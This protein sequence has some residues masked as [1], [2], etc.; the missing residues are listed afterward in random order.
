MGADAETGERLWRA[1]NDLANLAP[2]VVDGT[3]FVVADHSIKAF[4]GAD[5]EKRW[6]FELED[7]P[8]SAATVVDNTA[9]FGSN[10]GFLYAISDQ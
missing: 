6:E 9:F 2:T 10:N 3:A 8:W 7:R 5:G 1:G 4:D